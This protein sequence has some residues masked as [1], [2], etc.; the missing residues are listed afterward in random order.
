MVV[1]VENGVTFI[2]TNL[3]KHK[4]IKSTVFKHSVKPQNN[5][6]TVTQC[7]NGRSG[8]ERFTWHVFFLMPIALQHCRSTTTASNVTITSLGVPACNIKV[9]IIP[10]CLGSRRSVDETSLFFFTTA[11]FAIKHFA[12][13]KMPLSLPKALFKMSELVYG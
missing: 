2:L 1:F 9:F 3:I 4:N 13:K 6:N 7:C 11:A 10:A 8:H 5:P 12:V